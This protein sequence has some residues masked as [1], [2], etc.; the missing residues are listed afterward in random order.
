MQAGLGSRVASMEVFSTWSGHWKSES[1]RRE[2]CRFG[3][4]VKGRCTSTHMGDVRE[5]G[6]RLSNNS[7]RAS[8]RSRELPDIWVQTIIPTILASTPKIPSFVYGF[9]SMCYS[10]LTRRPSVPHRKSPRVHRPAQS[11]YILRSTKSTHLA[12]PTGTT[13]QSPCLKICSQR[14]DQKKR[15]HMPKHPLHRLA[16]PATH[17]STST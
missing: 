15:P 6:L 16:Q 11:R 1:D 5:R 8:T 10:F 12:W 3:D 2:G 17:Q 4:A 7:P 13:V 9:M 14:S